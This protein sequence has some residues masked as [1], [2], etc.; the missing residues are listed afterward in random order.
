MERLPD[1]ALAPASPAE[2]ALR[3]DL[4]AAYRLAA[5]RGWD[6][7]V[8]THLTARVPDEP[9]HFLINRFG[10][11]FSE[12]TASNLVKIDAAGRV[13]GAR[14]PVNPG[15]FALH[16]AV[17]AARPDAHCV[18]H[19]HAT[20]AVAVS[21]QA[22]GLLPLSQHALRF[23][24]RIGY[25]DYGGLDFPP[26]EAARMVAALA[27][28]PALLLRNHG[29]LVCGRTV[30]QAWVLMETLEKA[31]DIQLRARA[32]GVP[33]L[34]PPTRVLQRTAAQL[35]ADEAAEGELEWPALLRLAARIAPD[36]AD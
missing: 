4:A 24:R 14:Q 3:R 31:C 9:G 28:H 17:H 19:L 34:L 30:A 15:G 21:V 27:D 20:A 11:H 5:H 12:V 29:S 36:Y 22:Q 10:L 33:L 7:L 16:A 32:S 25:H 23:Y 8:Y 2:Q 6:D 35:T 26:A 13:V 1:H 18:I